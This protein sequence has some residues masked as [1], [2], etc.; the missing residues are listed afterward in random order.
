MKHI[1]REEDNNNKGEDMNT[2]S[3]VKQIFLNTALGHVQQLDNCAKE[4]GHDI[5]DRS[6]LEHIR[7]TLMAEKNKE[8]SYEMLRSK[9]H[10][11]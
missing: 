2:R 7:H 8:H 5:I 11:K 3:H 4:L 9:L 6:Y 10:H 1:E